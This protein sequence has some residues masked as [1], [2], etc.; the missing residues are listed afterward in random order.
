MLDLAPG[1]Y[2]HFYRQPVRHQHWRGFPTRS[3]KA[4]LSRSIDIYRVRRPWSRL[5]TLAIAGST[6]TTLPDRIELLKSLSKIIFL[7]KLLPSG[8]T[9][10]TSS[11][12]L[13]NM[14][15]GLPC[16][17]PICQPKAQQPQSRLCQTQSDPRVGMSKIDDP[18][19]WRNRSIT[20]CECSRSGHFQNS[21]SG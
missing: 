11:R 2:R 10:R 20:L 4:D 5:P 18:N 15:I 1:I 6:C 3:A 21:L 9:W 7:P 14:T 19:I 17:L 13:H 8:S 16:S 12:R